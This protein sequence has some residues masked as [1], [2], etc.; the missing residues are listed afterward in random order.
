MNTLLTCPEGLSKY[1]LE[2]KKNW[3]E[4]NECSSRYYIKMYIISEGKTR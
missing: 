4:K 1:V 3:K 2:R